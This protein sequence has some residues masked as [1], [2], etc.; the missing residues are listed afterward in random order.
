[1]GV[2]SYKGECIIATDALCRHY[3]VDALIRLHADDFDM[4]A[5]VGEMFTHFN[6]EFTSNA[7]GRRYAIL[8]IVKTGRRLPD[9]QEVLPIVDIERFRL[10]ICVETIQHVELNAVT[11]AQFA[12]SLPTIRTLADLGTALIRRYRSMFPDLTDAD[13]VARGCAVTRLQLDR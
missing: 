6:L 1:M 3:Q 11:P 5:S 2:V 8:P 13:I 9:G 4:L 10:G 12:E 7:V